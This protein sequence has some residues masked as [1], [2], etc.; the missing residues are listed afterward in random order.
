MKEIKS[1]FFVFSLIFIVFFSGSAR[2]SETEIIA[3]HNAVQEFDNIPQ[4]WIDQVKTM[5]LVH[6]GQSHGWQ[7]PMGL[8]DLNNDA[9][10][11]DEG[12]PSGKGFKVSR[13]LRSQYND[14]SASIGP[15]RFWQGEAGKDWVRRTLN[16][17][18]NNGVQVDAILHTWCWHFRTWS[19]EQLNDYFVAMEELEAEYPNVTFIY[20]TD[21]A[22]RSGDVNRNARNEQVRQYCLS[23]NKVLFDFGEIETWSADGTVRNWSGGVPYWHNDSGIGV[24]DDYGHISPTGALM[25]SKAMW[26]LMARIAGWNNPST[27]IND[28]QVTDER[29][30]KMLTLDKNY[31]NPFNPKTII[32]YGLPSATP[33]VIE[34]YNMLGQKI[35]TL[36]NENKA[37]GY[38]ELKFNANQLA[39]GIYIYTIQAGEYNKVMKMVIMK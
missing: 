11:I 37:A 13:G 19:A 2:T 25:K 20:M 28:S 6:T 35:T 23:H 9:L 1:Y 26:W 5:F 7:V 15:D 34:I 12:Y 17:Y 39:S 24:S 22:D 31:P 3:D 29:I 21:T 18:A 16:Y 4:Q 38:Y 32:R 8:Q 33:V 14:W 36:V 30:P 27:F 10:V